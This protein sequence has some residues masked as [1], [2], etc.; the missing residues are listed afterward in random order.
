M[1]TYVNTTTIHYTYIS[2]CF[3]YYFN[4]HHAYI[5]IYIYITY[6]Y[7]LY[8]Y[9]FFIYIYIYRHASIYI[10]IQSLEPGKPCGF[11]RSGRSHSWNGPGVEEVTGFDESKENPVPSFG[12]QMVDKDWSLLM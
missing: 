8:I 12:N 10:Y 6:V 7:I 1:Q 4:I 9:I 11:Q 5:Y 2:L 3:T